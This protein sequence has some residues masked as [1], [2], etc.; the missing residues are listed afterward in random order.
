MNSTNANRSAYLD[1]LGIRQWVLRVSGFGELAEA[2]EV[3]SECVQQ[4]SEIKVSADELQR[5]DLSGLA[6]HVA[7]CKACA[8]HATRKQTVFGTGHHKADWLIIG[9]APGAD[10]DR[11]GEP[12]VGRAGQLLTQMLRAIGLA[13]EEVFIANILKCRPPNNR[14]PKAE[15]V[16]ACRHYLNRQIELLQPK[17]ILALGRIAAQSLLQTDT[18]IGKMRGRLYHLD[19][20][21][22]P[23]V[24]TYHPA[25]LLRSPKE[26]RKVWED[27]KFARQQV[28][29][30]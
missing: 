3:A 25:Y 23:T 14:D 30:S 26:K 17:I 1:A 21:Q 10:E 6:K 28:L 24:V 29:G 8:L 11:Q 20:Y 5:F 19:Q 9:E 15:E 18:P 16:S 4:G 7:D 13:R 27:L 22:I 2:V 12:F